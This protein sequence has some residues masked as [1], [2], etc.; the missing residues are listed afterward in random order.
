M[1]GGSNLFRII[2]SQVHTKYGRKK[3]LS[4]C[5]LHL[6][7]LCYILFFYMPETSDKC[8]KCQGELQTKLIPTDRYT[9]YARIRQC[10]KCGWIHHRWVGWND[11]FLKCFED[12]AELRDVSSSSPASPKDFQCTECGRVY[13]LDRFLLYRK[14]S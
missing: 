14:E 5:L 2:N 7:L 4:N 6:P 12:N 3:P 1:F 13:L 10:I 11:E 9:K 8:P